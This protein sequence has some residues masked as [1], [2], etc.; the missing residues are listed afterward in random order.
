MGILLFLRHGYLNLTPLLPL[1]SITRLTMLTAK[2]MLSGK[3]KEHAICDKL[4]GFSKISYWQ[5][6][7]LAP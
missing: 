5:T 1:K 7:F 3:H 4:D 6:G 2:H